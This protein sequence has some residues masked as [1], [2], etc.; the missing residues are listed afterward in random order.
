M[1][2]AGTMTH[3]GPPAGFRSLRSPFAPVDRYS[4]SVSMR[5]RG[6]MQ[7]MRNGIVPVL[8]KR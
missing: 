4:H 1:L 5:A 2:K 6:W 7:T 3:H 8:V